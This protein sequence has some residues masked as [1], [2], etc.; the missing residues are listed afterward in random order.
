MQP[1][2]LA[3]GT[4]VLTFALLA[5]SCGGKTPKRAWSGDLARCE[6]TG[7]ISPGEA[8]PDC[9]FEVLNATDPIQLSN[10]HGR[11]FVLNFWASWCAACIKEMPAFQRV[12][13]DLKAQVAFVGMNVVGVQGET[14]GDAAEFAK[15]TGATYPIAL[16][17]DGLLYSHFSLRS[18]LPATVFVNANGIVVERHFGELDEEGLRSRI[19]GFLH[20][21]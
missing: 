16:D 11:P 7:L 10:L 2:N 17:T 5:S 14:R 15:R 12:F 4:A 8:L 9:S 20:V 18:I 21:R 1:R 13:V 6:P 19:E 3:L